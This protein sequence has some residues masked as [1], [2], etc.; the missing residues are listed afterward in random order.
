M[1][2]SAYAGLSG[3][4]A[5]Y[6]TTPAGLAERELYGHVI[7]VGE[8]GTTYARR[9]KNGPGSGIGGV[10]VAS[11]TYEALEADRAIYSSTNGLGSSYKVPG[12]DPNALYYHGVCSRPIAERALFSQG[13]V[14][15]LNGEHR[16]LK[17]VPERAS[18][19]F[20]NL[21]FLAHQLD[22]RTDLCSVFVVWQAP[23]WFDKVHV[24]R[25]P[26][27]SQWWVS[28]TPPS[29]AIRNAY[30]HPPRKTHVVVAAVDSD[31]KVALSRCGHAGV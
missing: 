16:L 12:L 7:S 6:S 25:D 3:G 10:A 22:L 1:A 2:A 19:C 30:A 9:P 17:Y 13:P 24:G 29:H 23:S 20:C 15:S 5:T 11:S 4:H 18:P 27:S 31:L 8:D 26:W 14:E 28:H 21:L